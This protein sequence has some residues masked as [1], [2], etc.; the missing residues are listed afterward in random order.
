MTVDHHALIALPKRLEIQPEFS[1]VV[2]S[3]VVKLTFCFS[4][5]IHSI[6]IYG[7]V[8]E[9]RAKAG[10]SDLDITII[11]RHETSQADKELLATVQS[12][13]EKANPVISKIDFD[14]G[15]LEQVVDPENLLSWGYWLKHHCR[16][17]YGEDLSCRFQAFKPSKAIALAVNGDFLQ[18]L[19]S[20]FIQIKTSSDVHKKLQL[21]RS[22]ARKLVRA[23]NIL[24]NEEDKDWPATLD[25]Y[26][27][28][29]NAGYPGLAEEMNYL[30]EMSY[31]PAGGVAVFEKRL[32]AFAHWLD[33]E[34]HYQKS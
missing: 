30:I 29:F 2:K 11:F 23:T 27:T 21:Q 18:V 1:Q 10:R 28:R 4:E 16:C 26:R 22:A 19:D 14:Y 32:M 31:Q 3:V 7:S 25:D 8:A 6:Y 34:F 15:Y 33:A 17:V 13:L 12:V 20:L 9:S 24:R 5:L